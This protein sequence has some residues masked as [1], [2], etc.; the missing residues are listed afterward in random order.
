MEN[1]TTKSLVKRC[2]GLDVLSGLR[3]PWQTQAALDRGEARLVWRG[4]GGICEVNRLF[5]NVVMSGSGKL[6]RMEAMEIY[7]E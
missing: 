6:G 4:E 2:F 7:A 5:L 1:N 3:Y